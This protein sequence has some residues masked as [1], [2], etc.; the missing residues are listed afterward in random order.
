LTAEHERL[1]LVH[2]E[3]EP[4]TQFELQKIPDRLEDIATELSKMRALLTKQQAKAAEDEP[5]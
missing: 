4:K 2:N 5:A 3:E 1:A